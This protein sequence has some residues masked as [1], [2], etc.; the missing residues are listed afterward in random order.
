MEGMKI[1][2]VGGVICFGEFA[3]TPQEFWIVVSYPR[4][5]FGW[6]YGGFITDPDIAGYLC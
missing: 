6:L 1:V 5:S 4:K 3:D 2:A